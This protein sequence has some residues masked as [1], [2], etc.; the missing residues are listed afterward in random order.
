MNFEPQKFYI[1][2]IDFF[3]IILPGALLTYMI[4][5][6]VTRAISGKFKFST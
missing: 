1:G 4:K 5:D 2:V 6:S 3:S